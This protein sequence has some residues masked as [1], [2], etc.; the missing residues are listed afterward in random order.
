MT[1]EE[2]VAAPSLTVSSSPHIHS[3]ESV[4]RIMFSVIGALVPAAILSVLLFGL[5]AARTLVICVAGC[6]VFELIFQK[7]L[8]KTVTIA[9][10]S[11]AL[12]GLLLAFNLPADVPWWLP[13]IGSAVAIG[14]AKQVFGGL[15]F[16]IFNP[17]LVARA[18][19]LISFPVQMTNWTSVRKLWSPETIDAV[20]A[21]TPLGQ[22]KEELLLAGQLGASQDRPILG[23]FLGDIPGS[24][25]E[26]SALVLLVGAIYLLYKG[27]ITWQIP[28]SFIGTVAAVAG[29]GH[30]IDPNQYAGPL[31]HVVSGG[32]ILGAF[33]M[34]TDMVTSPISGKGQLIFG[35]GC[36]LITVV[37]RLWGG[38]PEGVSFAIL[39]MNA[40]TPL[41]DR[42][43]KTPLFGKIKVNKA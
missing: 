13:L 12:T 4:P 25:G 6:V 9:D 29:I 37:I 30:L 15:G 27:Y 18:F 40:A 34:A 23:M 38:Y 8:H 24:L 19:L 39:I 21:A 36:G 16:N 1:K 22:M 28:V 42:W 33:F 3:G 32:L 17:A 10:G 41:I 7:L 11:A 14:L 31:F 26:M 43:V 35:F 5:P 2:K 20:S